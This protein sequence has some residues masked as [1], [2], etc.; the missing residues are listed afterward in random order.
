[1]LPTEHCIKDSIGYQIYGK[2]NEYKK[3]SLAIINH[4]TFPSI[5]LAEYLKGHTEYDTV[6]LCGLYSHMQVFSNAIMVK[7]VLKES[8]ISVLKNYTATFDSS[9]EA[10]SFNLLNALHI[11]INNK[12]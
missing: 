3:S 12:L 7:S 5:E 1:M 4:Q 6:D 9:L 8:L 10:K 2:V 11:E